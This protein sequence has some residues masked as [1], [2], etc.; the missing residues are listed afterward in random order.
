MMSICGLLTASERPLS[1][2]RLAIAAS[3]HPWERTHVAKPARRSINQN[4]AKIRR[5]HRT[6]PSARV[7]DREHSVFQHARLKPFLDQV[8]HAPIS[9]PMLQETDQPLLADRIE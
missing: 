8:D 7:T 5:D 2:L 3:S 4:A 6:L 1:S 9:N